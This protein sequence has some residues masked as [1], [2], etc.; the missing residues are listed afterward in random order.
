[1]SHF[2]LVERAQIPG[3]RSSQQLNCVRWR[4]LFVDPQSELA[5]CHFSCAQTFKVAPTLL[6]VMQ[7]CSSLYDKTTSYYRNTEF[8]S[9]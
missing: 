4:H 7:A 6:R 8:Y 2:K 1:M 3:A 9:L 5:S